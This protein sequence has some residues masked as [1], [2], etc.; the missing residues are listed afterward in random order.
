MPPTHVC[1][2][3][4]RLREKKIKFKNILK[5]C[6]NSSPKFLNIS[7]SK[8][9]NNT[10][11]PLSLFTYFVLC[12]KEVNYLKLRKLLEEGTGVFACIAYI[13]TPLLNVLM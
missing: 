6:K 4:Q 7:Q 2:H 10:N 9:W 5:L 11:S 3:T 1:A 8:V 12:K 13:G